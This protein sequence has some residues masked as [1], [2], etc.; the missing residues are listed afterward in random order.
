MG[1]NLGHVFH[2]HITVIGEPISSRPLP[3]GVGNP[4]TASLVELSTGSGQLVA[5]QHTNKGRDICR[6][7]HLDLFFGPD[8]AGHIRARRG[9]HGVDE[10]VI[11]GAFPGQRVGEANDA[12]FLASTLVCRLTWVN[13]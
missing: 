13:G 6:I 5:G 2:G 3:P 12:A 11:F 4:P 9:G 7:H 10:D 8:G 1:A